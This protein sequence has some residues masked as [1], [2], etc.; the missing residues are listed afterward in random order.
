MIDMLTLKPGDK[1]LLREN[2]TAEVLENMED[3][4]WVQVRYVDVPGDAGQVGE[5]ELCHAQDIVR[6]ASAS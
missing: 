5:V 2:V 3:G 1:L 4:M 6:V